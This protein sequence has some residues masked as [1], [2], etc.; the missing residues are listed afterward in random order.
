MAKQPEED[1]GTRRLKLW[2]GL[3]NAGINRNDI[4]GGARKDPEPPYQK[5]NTVGMRPEFL[6]RH[7][8]KI[9][10]HVEDLRSQGMKVT[11]NHFGCGHTTVGSVERSNPV[12][13]GL[14]ENHY[15]MSQCRSCTLR[16]IEG[17]E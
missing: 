11:L 16:G 5:F 10:N 15:S 7:S 9:I 17:G 6:E 3:A 1:Y 2:E 13:R 14:K 8:E 12:R 4:V